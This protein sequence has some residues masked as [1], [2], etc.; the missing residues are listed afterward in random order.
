MIISIIS[1]IYNEEDFLQNLLKKINFFY[2][3]YQ[4][5][6]IFID[7]NSTDNSFKILQEFAEKKDKIRLIKNSG[8]G[9]VDAINEGFKLCKGDFIKLVAGD[10]EI[11]LSFIELIEKYN[12]GE[13]A[14]VH[15]AK[16][17]DENNLII[18]NYIPPYQLISYDLDRYILNNI[19]CPSWCWIF[20]REQAKKFFPI[21]EC[22]YEDLYLS[23]CIKKFSKIIYLKNFYYN[24]KQ[25][26]GQTFG[27]ILKFDKKIGVYRS[28][29]V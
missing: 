13:T 29:E 23:F 21:P 12:D 1:P 19:S 18:G 6:W 25:N 28:K 9:K 22:E 4:F 11:D 3:K 16:I 14:F 26:S 8:K 20:P 10:D 15:D 7:D 2:E 17:S 5:E 24:F 27:N